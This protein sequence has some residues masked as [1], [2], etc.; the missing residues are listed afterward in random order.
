MPSDS[1]RLKINER[2]NHKVP[3]HYQGVDE[4]EGVPG[5][6][7]TS[8]FALAAFAA[9]YFEQWSVNVPFL[10]KVRICCNCRKQMC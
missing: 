3:F 10:L 8:V 7:Y 5:A 1:R 4:G 2:Q 6:E 9:Q